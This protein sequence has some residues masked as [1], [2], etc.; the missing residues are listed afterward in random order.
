VVSWWLVPC[1]EVW[2]TGDVLSKGVAAQYRWLS[3]R[4]DKL[5]IRCIQTSDGIP[6]I[7]DSR[8]RVERED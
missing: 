1:H 5:D 8:F 3:L 2:R 7:A 4:K 6:P